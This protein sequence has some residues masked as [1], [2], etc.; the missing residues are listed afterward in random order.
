MIV[1]DRFVVIVLEKVR[2]HICLV[3]F[4]LQMEI[5]QADMTTHFF[6]DYYDEPVFYDHPNIKQP[7]TVKELEALIANAHGV[8]KSELAQQLEGVQ[9]TEQLDSSK[10]A[11]LEKELRGSE[12]R[13]AQIG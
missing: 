9:L 7:V 12:A 6:E 1:K 3:D 2:C 13:E 10:L 5:N 11:K 8:S 4:H